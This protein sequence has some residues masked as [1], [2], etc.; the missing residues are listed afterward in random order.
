MASR[1]LTGRSNVAVLWACIDGDSLCGAPAIGARRFQ[2]YLA[3]FSDE[4]D[5]RQA[6][7]DAG[8]DPLT[9]AAEERR[10]GRRAR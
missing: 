3:P 6:L 4:P 7:L 2:A 1:F 10:R 9:I 5:A 8:A